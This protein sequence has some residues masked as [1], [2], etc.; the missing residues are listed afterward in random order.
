M[1]L[2]LAFDTAVAGKPPPP[3]V[4]RQSSRTLYNGLAHEVSAFGG[5]R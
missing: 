1:L 4:K 5:C 3:A 2:A